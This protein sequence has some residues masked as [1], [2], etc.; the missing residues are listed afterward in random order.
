M[1]RVVT[2]T[3]RARAFVAKLKVGMAAIEVSNVIQRVAWDT[4]RR[5]VRATPKKWTG[6]TRRGWTV[7]R[8]TGAGW[9]VTNEYQVMGFLES[10]TKAHGPKTKKAL[11]IPLKSKALA[12]WDASLV[13][14]KD[15]VLAK[16]VKGIKALHIVEKERPQAQRR[17]KAA[18]DKFTRK[19]IQRS[20]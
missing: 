4:H 9:A 16:R 12:G 15:Y 10:G 19:A 17:L 6:Q 13:Y 2:R 20:K 3:E 8:S 14:G 18:I 7:K 11:F 5:L 1:I